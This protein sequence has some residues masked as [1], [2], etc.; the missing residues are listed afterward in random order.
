[1]CV[2]RRACHTL[3]R[4]VSV[5]YHIVVCVCVYAYVSAT[6]ADTDLSRLLLLVAYSFASPWRVL[7]VKL[8]TRNSHR[9]LHGA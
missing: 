8:R 5:S 9:L 6:V 3:H 1:M 4:D 7:H 2:I